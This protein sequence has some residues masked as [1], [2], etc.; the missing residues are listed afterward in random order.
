MRAISSFLTIVI[1]AIV[2]WFAIANR[3]A[4]ELTLDPL[5][6]SVSVPFYLPVLIAVLLGLIAGGLISWRASGGR[7]SRLRQAE[8]Q[9][10]ELQQ[11]LNNRPNDGSRT[12][13][14]SKT[15]ERAD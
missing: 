15:L 1:A 3:H 2:V 6:L 4:V 12:E 7:R 11:S 14:P 5:P 10:D 13:P 9:R 8:R